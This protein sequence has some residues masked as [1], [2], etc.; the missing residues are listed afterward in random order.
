MK[1]SQGFTLIELMIVIAVIGVLAAIAIP[2]YNEHVMRSR[3]TGATSALA[4]MQVRMEQYF[5]DNRTYVGACV[6][7][8]VAR[9]PANTAAFT[10]T[11][12][13][14]SATDY[15]IVATGAGPMAN[16]IFN[17]TQSGKSTTGAPAG[18]PTNPNCWVTSKGG[19]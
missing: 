11:C 19:C 12:P 7:N 8:T 4:D 3:I 14:P 18:W 10:F 17:L 9:M 5:Q 13:A 1:R 16:F 2:N 6:A 15:T